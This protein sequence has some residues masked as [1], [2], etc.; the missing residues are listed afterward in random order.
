MIPENVGSWEI[1]SENTPP[2]GFTMHTNTFLNLS[3]STTDICLFLKSMQL[4]IT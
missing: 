2:W 3:N 1:T 4:Q